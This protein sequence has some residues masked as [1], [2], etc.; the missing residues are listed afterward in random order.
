MSD[1]DA[2]AAA[3]PRDALLDAAEQLLLTVGQAGLTTR[4]VAEQAGVNHGLVHYYF[5]SMEELVF[6]VVVRFNDRLLQRQREMYASDRPF[7]EKWR[8]AMS[9]MEDD[10]AAGFPRVAMELIAM[11]WNSPALRERV[12]WSMQRWSEVLVE[13][14]TAALDEYGIPRDSFP[15][16][17]A[18]GIVT[19]ATLGLYLQ[20]LTGIDQGQEHMLALADHWIAGLDARK[21]S[22]EDGRSA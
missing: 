13:A 4:K 10:L 9:F 17:A 19:A 5:G 11:S 18:L 7:L 12:V 16:D 2:G 20:R 1:H 15:M 8:L 14:F 22:S 3:H 21:P 6:Q